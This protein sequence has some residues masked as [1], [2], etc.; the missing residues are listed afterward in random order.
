MNWTYIKDK[1]PEVSSNWVAFS[2]WNRRT[3]KSYV[4]VGRVFKDGECISRDMINRDV[5]AYCELTPAELLPSM[6]DLVGRLR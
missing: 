3:R 4:E 2:C 1:E 5:Y 6:I